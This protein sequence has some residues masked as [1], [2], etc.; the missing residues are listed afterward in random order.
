MLPMQTALFTPNI[1]E[2]NRLASKQVLVM[3]API[4]STTSDVTPTTRGSQLMLLHPT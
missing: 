1:F 4:P 3:G 2:S